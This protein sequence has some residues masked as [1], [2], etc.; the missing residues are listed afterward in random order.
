MLI[1][2]S[3][4]RDEVERLQV[5]LATKAFRHA[6]PG[7]EFTLSS[8]QKSKLYFES[9][10]VT[11]SSEAFTVI[12]KLFRDEALRWG[13]TA[14]GGLSAGAI[15]IAMAVVGIEANEN[16]QRVRAF[17]VRDG[18]KEHGTKKALFE[19]FD[20]TGAS[21]VVSSGSKVFVVDDVL[22]TGNSISKAMD[23]LAHEQAVVVAISVLVDRGQ[24][25]AANLRGRYNVPVT[26]MYKADSQGNLSFHG[27]EVF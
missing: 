3:V 23:E 6:A 18:A 16:S 5:L 13:A 10:Y 4:T 21:G 12:G 20:P 26:A 8:G 1:T 22:T 17:Y 25:G 2:R 19:A 14:I 9:K 15:P 27:E 24:G 11:L 7:E